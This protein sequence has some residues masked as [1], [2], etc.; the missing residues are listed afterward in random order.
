MAAFCDPDPRRS[1]P[2]QNRSGERRRPHRSDVAAGSPA[3]VQ[4]SGQRLDVLLPGCRAA[5]TGDTVLVPAST[6]HRFSS[7]A[8]GSIPLDLTLTTLAV[9]HSEN[10]Y[11]VLIYEANKNGVHQAE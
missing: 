8:P 4:P 10:D 1:R 3:P 9:D 6:I 11:T 5:R 7:P 2:H